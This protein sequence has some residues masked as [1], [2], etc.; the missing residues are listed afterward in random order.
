MSLDLSRRM[1]ISLDLAE[2]ALG[3]GGGRV[4]VGG[5]AKGS[6]GK[7]GDEVHLE[8]LERGLDVVSVAEDAVQGVQGSEDLRVRV[9]CRVF[10]GCARR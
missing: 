8:S 1:V 7:L 2:G 5:G 9:D 3:S 10:L 4:R 6:G